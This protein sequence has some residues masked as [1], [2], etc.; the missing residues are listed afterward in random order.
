MDP[1]T[2]GG[3]GMILS[4]ATGFL[5][6]LGMVNILGE[7]GAAQACSQSTIALAVGAIVWFLTFAGLM[8]ILR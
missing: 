8:K 2:A 7:G 1:D 5:A 3:L 6:A 4:L